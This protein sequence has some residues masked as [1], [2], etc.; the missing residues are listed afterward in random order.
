MP[1]GTGA[2]SLRNL[3]TAAYEVNPAKFF[4]LTE[5]NIFAPANFDLPAPANYTTKQLLQ[6]GVVS[7]LQII[8]KGTAAVTAAAGNTVTKNYKWPYG[9]LKNVTVSGN[10]VNNFINCSGYDLYIR[11]LCQYRAFVDN[12]TIDNV[13][14]GALAANGNYTFQVAIEIPLAMDDS[15][16]IGSLYAQSEATNLTVQ[17]TTESIANLFTLVGTGAVSFLN[18]AGTAA[19]NPTVYLQETFFEVP[20]DPQKPGTLVIPDLTVLHGIIANDNPVAGM[21]TVTTEVY[22]INGQMER[23]IYYCDNNNA[24]V[25]TANYARHRLV[26]GGS[27]TPLDFNPP[28][29]LRILNNEWY[30]LALPD[31]VYSLDMIAENPQRDQILLEGI[32]NLRLVTDYAG[33]FVP[34]AA[35][36]MHFVQ[37]TLFA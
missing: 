37:E 26:Y 28:D 10:G 17:I 21:G 22:R 20:Y 3:P 29:Q 9:I 16:L 27:Q 36:R 5:R 32:T 15:S 34:N 8:I 1:T 35:A 12:Y 2:V 24:L 14:A 18:F 19:T 31:G 7:K 33:G 11:K 25:T 6:V 30:R 4:A 23:L 13:P